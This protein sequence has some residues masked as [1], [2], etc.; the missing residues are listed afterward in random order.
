MYRV[1]ENW[2]SSLHK[3]QKKMLNCRRRNSLN[4]KSLNLK[5]WKRR[6]VK[7]NMMRLKRRKNLNY[8]CLKMRKMRK[9][10]SLN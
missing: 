7:M 2:R 5:S 8:C 10:N 4:L 3:N 6:T 1:K 9:M